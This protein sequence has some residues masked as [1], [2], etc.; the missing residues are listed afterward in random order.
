MSHNW[1]ILINLC[2]KFSTKHTFSIRV[3]KTLPILPILRIC[4]FELSPKETSLPFFILVKLKTIYSF[5]LYALNNHCPSTIYFSSSSC[6]VEK[7]SSFR[8]PK[9][10]GSL[11]V[12]N[13]FFWNLNA[14]PTIICISF[15][16]TPIFHMT[17]LITKVPY[18]LIATRCT[19]HKAV[20]IIFLFQ[21][22]LI[23]NTSLVKHTFFWIEHAI[24]YLLPFV[25][26]KTILFNPLLFFLSVS[27]SFFQI[28]YVWF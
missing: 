14:F 16:W 24:Q 6:P 7:I 10:F 12:S 22:W 23:I 2:F 5:R 11:R 17:I 4:P 19:L 27:F 28:I 25:N 1:L 26:F 9:L 20:L 15:Y 21:V 13:C 3:E 8:Y 18:N